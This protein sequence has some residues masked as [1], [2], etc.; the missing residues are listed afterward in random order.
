MINLG[1]PESNVEK[2]KEVYPDNYC[3]D[4]KW[5]KKGIFTPLYLAKCKR[6]YQIERFDY[7]KPPK[8][9][10]PVVDRTRITECRGIGWESK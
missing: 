6:F 5:I 2:E 7:T 1:M 9:Y 4:C 10:Y 3:I 8:I